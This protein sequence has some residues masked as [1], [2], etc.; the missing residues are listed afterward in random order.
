MKKI[1]FLCALF[2]FAFL[3]SQ[4]QQTAA[5]YI[6][7]TNYLVYLPDGYTQ[8]TTKRWPVMLFLHGS[9]ERGNDIEKVKAHGPPRLAA[10][11]RKFPFIIISPQAEPGYGW[12]DDELYRLLQYAKR[13]YRVDPD[14]IYLTGLSMGGY[15]TWRL[16]MA[17]PE[18]FAAIIPICGGGDSSNIWKLRHMPVWCFHGA[19]DN[20]VPLSASE[21]MIKALKRYNSGVK[22]TVYPETGHD[23]WVQAY[24]TDSLY[25]WLLAQ[26]KFRHTPV[27]ATATMLS[28]LAGKYSSGKV[29][30]TIIASNDTLYVKPPNEER[31]TLKYAGGNIFYWNE[32]EPYDVEFVKDNKG[33]A[34]YFVV[35]ANNSEI[36]NRVKE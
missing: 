1:S 8:D 15:G 33:V 20:S 26:K 28:S 32:N 6:R 2:C 16:A 4:A 5:K 21:S 7:E 22:F 13:Q 14:R 30:L 29:T 3:C 12:V 36:F 27:Q 31:T 11:G 35:R 9:G 17:H 34:R 25:Q 24:Q 23:S 18:E 19:K 10:E